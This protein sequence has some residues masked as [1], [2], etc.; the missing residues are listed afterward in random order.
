MAALRPEVKYDELTLHGRLLIR[1]QAN[2]DIA[3]F[4]VPGAN[5]C[6]ASLI[7]GALVLPG[8]VVKGNHEQ[9]RRLLGDIIGMEDL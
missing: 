8:L 6:R 1:R 5:S 7:A 3:T 4:P 9:L 2:G